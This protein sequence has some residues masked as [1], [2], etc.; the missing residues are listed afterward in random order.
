MTMLVAKKGFDGGYQA[1]I[2]AANEVLPDAERLG[3]DEERVRLLNLRGDARVAFGDDGGF[4]DLARSIELAA[5]THAY[6]HLHSAL[7]NLMARQLGR[8]WLEQAQETLEAM[9]LN[10]ERRP[11]AAE[12]RW[13]NAVEAEIEYTSGGWRESLSLLDALVADSE[14]QFPHYLDS[15]VRNLRA[16][17]WRGRGERGRAA[18]DSAKALEEARRTGEAQLIGLA[19]VGRAIALL[20]EG[21]AEASSLAAE[22]LGLNPLV[23]N[24]WTLVEAAWVMRDLGFVEKY[25]AWLAKQPDSPWT[26]AAELICGADFARAA[27]ALAEIRHRPGEAYARLRAARELVEEGRRAE[28]DAQLQRSLAFWREVG[29]TRYVREGEALLAVSA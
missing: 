17:I 26:G 9:K 21:S 4:D 5:Q 27:D 19:L 14:A 7:N 12:R 13:V 29:A 10:L 20:D 2:D 24:D 25:Q 11:A 22:A 16:A 15:V 3:L 6:E 23:L 18:E 1:G 8:G 28:A